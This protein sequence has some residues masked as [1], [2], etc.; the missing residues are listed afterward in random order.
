[1]DLYTTSDPEYPVYTQP[2][3]I[4]FQSINNNV[5]FLVSHE[6]YE[7]DE[8]QFQQ[9]NL[10]DSNIETRMKPIHAKQIVNYEYD[11]RKK[12]KYF[13]NLDYLKKR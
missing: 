13:T 10:N 8:S 2:L 1:M 9:F 5:V 6:H 4:I 12:S 7:F 3:S 11:I